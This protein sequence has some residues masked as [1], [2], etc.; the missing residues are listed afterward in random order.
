[1]MHAITTVLLQSGLALCALDAPADNPPIVADF[2]LQDPRGRKV[3]LRECTEKGPAVLVFL[4]ADCPVTRRYSPILRDLHATYSAAGV[5]IVGINSNAQDSD[6]DVVRF[7]TDFDIPFPI[8]KDSGAV[9]ADEL[10]VERTPTAILIDKQ[11]RI[12]YHGRIDDQHELDFDRPN[13]TRLDLVVA[14]AELTAGRPVTLPSTSVSGCRIG[15]Q[16]RRSGDA[17]FTWH[18]HIA[19][20][21]RDHCHQCH[22]A[23]RTA[24]FPLVRFEDVEGWGP[25]IDEVIKLRRMPPWKTDPRC[26]SFANA[27]SLTNDEIEAVSRWVADGCPEGESGSG[28]SSLSYATGWQLS[29]K[30][31]KI[32]PMN[33]SGYSVPAQGSIDYRYYV[34]DPGF[35]ASVKI[36]GAEILPGNPNVVWQAAVFVLPPGL[37][38]SPEALADRSESHSN[39]LCWFAP[40]AAPIEYPPDAAK[41][42]PAGGK[43][44][45]Q[46]CYRS[47]GRVLEDHTSIGILFADPKKV[48]RIVRTIPIVDADF[49][50]PPHDQRF[51]LT[52]Q[53]LMSDDY[54]LISLIPRMNLR[55][56]SFRVTAKPKQGK[57]TMLLEVP[58]FS[59]YWQFEYRLADPSPIDQGTLVECIA[60]Y[61]N[62]EENHVNPDPTSDV[63]SGGRI[64]N[65]QMAAYLEVIPRLT[66]AFL[67]VADG[68]VLRDPSR[69][70][71]MALGGLAAATV[72]CLVILWLKPVA[73]RAPSGSTPNL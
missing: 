38:G 12:R 34:V 26:D 20:I 43:L 37:A 13:A 72:I 22:R 9:L 55:G 60:N 35:D 5:A 2:S 56:R 23:G 59:P 36:A 52:Q 57:P 51:T 40:G 53:A 4:G 65:E 42:F 68:P 48:R 16:T 15:R 47:C 18:N 50:I 73:A 58:R 54:D 21:I 49:S 67:D 41:E 64:A 44:L 69:D 1:M 33:Q 10:R 3:T 24:N 61:D 39:L 63:V 71:S 25:M 29:R 11:R 19:A 14:I 17:K 70:I 45:F 27:K 62:S 31:D 28:T 32:I 30:P 46:I 6:A 66:T 7:A 8:V